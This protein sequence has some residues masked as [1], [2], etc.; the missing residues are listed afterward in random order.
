[1]Q[2]P[3]ALVTETQKPL[4]SRA[5]VFLI[6]VSCFDLEPELFSVLS[7]FFFFSNDK[8]KHALRHDYHV[9]FLSET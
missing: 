4:L 5:V 6:H 1:M 3:S 2:I 8:S 7:S 9:L